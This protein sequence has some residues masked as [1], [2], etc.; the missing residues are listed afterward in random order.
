M[1]V[2]GQHI[3]NSDIGDCDRA[4]ALCHNIFGPAGGVV[5]P[6]K[7]CHSS[8]LFTVQNIHLYFTNR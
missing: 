8:S 2:R 4:S 5:D 3:N 1:P 6:V 7:I